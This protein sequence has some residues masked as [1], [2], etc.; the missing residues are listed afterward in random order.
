VR[1]FD[2]RVWCVPKRGGLNDSA[3]TG[4]HVARHRVAQ[5]GGSDYRLARAIALR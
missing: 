3:F 2:G 5:L 4:R 1:L